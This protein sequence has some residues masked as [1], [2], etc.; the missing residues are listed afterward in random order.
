MIDPRVKKLAEL[1]VDYSV[2]VKKGENV[3][4]SGSSTESSLIKEIYRLVI[5]RGAYPYVDIGLPG[6]SYIYYKHASIEQLKKFPKI[7][8]Y[9]IRNCQKYIG[10]GSPTNTR[11]FS[12]IDPKK[13]AIRSKVTRPI[14]DYVVNSQP[15]MYRTTLDYPTAALAQDAEMSTEEY[16]EFLFSACLLDWKKL[17]KRFTHLQKVLNGGKVVRIVGEDTDLT[18][19]IYKKS[20]VV[21]DGKENMPGGE[22]FCAPEKFSAEGHI[23]FTYP[24]IRDSTQVDNIY[25][26]FKKGK[27]V[28]ATADKN[29]KFLKQMIALDKGSCY[30]GELGIGMNPKINKFTKNLLFDEKIGGTIHLALGMAYKQ[31]GEP[32]KSALHWDIVK[33][34]RKGGAIYLD[35]KLIQKNGKWL[36]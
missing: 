14:S 7:R 22:I 26:E 27:V 18:L 23:R 32:N 30:L 13:L 1:L 21:D 20:F 31:C 2:F 35:G 33:D 11:E 24:A 6:M 29:E 4:I 28:K 10:I 36:V 8:D 12:N 34:L 19:R 3:A 17:S 9:V 15:K 25:I 5:K 16:E